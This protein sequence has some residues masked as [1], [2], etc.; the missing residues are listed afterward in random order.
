MTLFAGLNEKMFAVYVPEKWSSNVHNL[1]RM[2]N[3]TALLALCDAA[4]GALAE[5]LLGLTRTTS[6]E[7]PN[8]VNQKRVQAQWV[9]WFRD[10][11]A[12]E[13][14]SSFLG[15]TVLEQNS[16]FNMAPQDKHINLAVV[17]QNDGLRIML[18]LGPSALVDRRNLAKKLDL[19]WERE[20]WVELC[21]HAAADLQIY[22]GGV[23]QQASG[24]AAQD[25]HD[26]V[27]QLGAEGQSIQLGWHMNIA[28]VLERAPEQLAQQVAGYLDALLPFY[29]FA[30][31]S[32]DNDLIE[33]GK[34]IQ[35]EKAQR[36][37]QATH[38]TT[39]D[40]VRFIAGLF[41][42][43]LG[44]VQGIDTKA[45]VKVQVGTMSVVVAGGDLTPAN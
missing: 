38:F 27:G 17:M 6:D 41:V 34:K 20:Q 36:R 44:V 30:A 7:I 45:Q 3:K 18:H 31:W 11:A 12:R 25:W 42:G 28:D 23:A 21:K 16:I 33:A 10:P 8:I 26:L 14:L 24:H 37:R 35:E 19:P 5:P 15:K 4:Q 1:T 43:K 13:S 9:Y 2:N 29:R 39:G 32:R 40:K 22:L